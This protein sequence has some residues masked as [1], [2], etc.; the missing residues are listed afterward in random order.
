MGPFGWHHNVRNA[1]AR[2]W[3]VAEFTTSGNDTDTDVEL[4]RFFYFH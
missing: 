4:K 2:D 3:L 1:G